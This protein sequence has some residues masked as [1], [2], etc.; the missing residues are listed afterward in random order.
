[1]K[2]IFSIEKEGVHNILKVFGL[3]FAFKDKFAEIQKI[4]KDLYYQ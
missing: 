4:N 3:K 1:M 2:S